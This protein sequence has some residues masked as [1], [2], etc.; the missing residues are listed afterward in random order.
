MV[1]A[2]SSNGVWAYS[3]PL[4]A[5]GRPK[6]LWRT[7]APD[8]VH[9]MVTGDVTGAG[10]PEEVVSADTAVWSYAVPTGQ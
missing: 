3:G 10:R 9:E 1:M 6:E 7:T 4:L 8:S 5:S 2:G